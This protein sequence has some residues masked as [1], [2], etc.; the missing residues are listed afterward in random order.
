M[1]IHVL[2]LTAKVASRFVHELLPV[3][4]ASV[5]G[6]LVVNHY[7]RQPASPP[8]VVQ[9]QPSASESA[10]EQSL[11]EDHALIASFM[12][13]TEER[14]IDD[15][16]SESL[17]TRTASFAPIA[18]SLADPP[19]PE[20][21]PAAPQKA[22]ARLG[23]KAEVKKK[24]AP[25]EAPASQPDPPAMASD[26]PPSPAT[27]PAPPRIEFEPGTR[28]IIRVA[29]AFGGWV[30][31]VAQAPARMAFLPRWPDWPSTPPLIRPLA[32]F[33]QNGS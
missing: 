12:K 2:D 29:S 10:I 26:N 24:S 33:R 20:P 1:A 14:D 15:R 32:F 6:A 9:A 5:I 4:L 13:R 18:L 27:L 7:G 21:R 17:G 3:A 30:A 23:P 22:A 25:I 31:E 8:I 19:L 28:P 11:R 16:R